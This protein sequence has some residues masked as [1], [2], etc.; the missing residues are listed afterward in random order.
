MTKD[1]KS[2]YDLAEKENDNLRAL[3]RWCLPKLPF[4]DQL[5]MLKLAGWSVLHAY[6]NSRMK[7]SEV[8]A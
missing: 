3:L 1:W 4:A 7:K 2:E 8:A 6:P 5:H